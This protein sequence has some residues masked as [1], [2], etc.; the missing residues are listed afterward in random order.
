MVLFLA[1]KDEPDDLT[2]LAP[3]PGDVCIALDTFTLNSNVVDDFVTPVGGD[4]LTPLLHQEKKLDFFV[5]TIDDG[6]SSCLSPA[7]SK[8]TYYVYLLDLVVSILIYS[9]LEFY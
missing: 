2:H 1:L 7:L 8:V 6:S 5:P 4:D 9:S 3:T